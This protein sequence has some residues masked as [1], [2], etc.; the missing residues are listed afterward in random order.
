[1]LR[2]FYLLARTTLDKVTSVILSAGALATF[3]IPPSWEAGRDKESVKKII[4]ELDSEPW[5]N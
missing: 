1:V 2:A 3:P 4:R 5:R